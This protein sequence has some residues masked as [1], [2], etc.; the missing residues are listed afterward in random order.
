MD[1]ICLWILAFLFYI[2]SI[3][4]GYVIGFKNGFNKSKKIDDQIID[5]LS[6]KYRQLN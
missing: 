1:N 5:E 2:T 6:K 3:Y 4:M